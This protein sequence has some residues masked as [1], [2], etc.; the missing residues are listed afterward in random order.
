M[1][2]VADFVNV[3]S[4]NEASEKIITEARDLV[5]GLRGEGVWRETGMVKGLNKTAQVVMSLNLAKLGATGGKALLTAAIK[6]GYVHKL[7]DH[8]RRV[9]QLFKDLTKQAAKEGKPTQH[10]IRDFAATQAARSVYAVPA[11]GLPAAGYA[12][13]KANEE[14]NQGADLSQRQDAAK[15]GFGA[16]TIYGA[17]S[18]ALGAASGTTKS[19]GSETLWQFMEALG[20]NEVMDW[21]SDMMGGERESSENSED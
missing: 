4:G 16:G 3:M 13:S 18:G 6:R 11:V 10:L 8:A 12:G 9:S 20:G 1:I 5:D 17:S 15:L 7:R 14:R 2:D 19:A 21:V